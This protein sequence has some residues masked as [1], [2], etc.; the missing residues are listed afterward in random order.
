MTTGLVGDV[1][2][3]VP[4]VHSEINEFLFLGKEEGPAEL[5]PWASRVWTV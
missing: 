1:I 4:W 5:S 2:V 3:G